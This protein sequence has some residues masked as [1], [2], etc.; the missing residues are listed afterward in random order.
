M[1][2]LVSL[3]LI[4]TVVAGVVAALLGGWAAMLS[5]VLGGMCCVVPNGIMAL[6]LFAK[7]EEAWRREPVIVF[8]LGI[9]KDCTDGGAVVATAHAVPRFELAG[10]DLAASS[11]R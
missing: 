7:H 3:Q 10:L 1:L 8:H 5:A 9:Y 4:A 6:R 2:R 11:W